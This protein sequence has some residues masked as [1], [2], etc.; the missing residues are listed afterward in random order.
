MQFYPR[1]GGDVLFGDF[2]TFHVHN[3]R[4]KTLQ[5]DRLKWKG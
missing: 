4:G 2:C 5:D 1:S 3:S